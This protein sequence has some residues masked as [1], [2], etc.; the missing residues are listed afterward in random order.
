MSD[1]KL[2]TII[3][4]LFGYP[5]STY[6]KW[7]TLVLGLIL[8]LGGTLDRRSKFLACKKKS[9]FRAFS[10]ARHTSSP[11]IPLSFF[12]FFLPFACVFFFFISFFLSFFLSFFRFFFL[13]FY[14]Y[15]F[16]FFFSFFFSFVLLCLFLLLFCFVWCCTFKNIFQSSL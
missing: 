9:A 16:L 11:A 15:L 1:W 13:S 8:N 3:L 6:N 12:L 14:F 4:P 10:F 7:L 5:K 2:Y